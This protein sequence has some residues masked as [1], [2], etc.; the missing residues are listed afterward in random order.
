MTC[1]VTTSS[2]TDFTPLLQAD[3]NI[4]QYSYRNYDKYKCECVLMLYTT[5]VVKGSLNILDIFHN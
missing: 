5:L 1:L 2:N 3:V 4:E